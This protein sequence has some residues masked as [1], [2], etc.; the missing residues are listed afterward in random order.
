[1]NSYHQIPLPS[2]S[3]HDFRWDK[4][5]CVRQRDKYNPEDN[6]VLENP[7]TT[8]QLIEAFCDEQESILNPPCYNEVALKDFLRKADLQDLNTARPVLALLDDRREQSGNDGSMRNWESDRYAREPLPGDCV[9][10]LI[11]DEGR[12]FLKLKEHVWSLC[13]PLARLNTDEAR[14]DYAI[15]QWSESPK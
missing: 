4:R 2:H 10:R 15:F 13:N 8:E 3:R 1:M 5:F 6:K 14:E 9:E 11:F 12:L 7:G